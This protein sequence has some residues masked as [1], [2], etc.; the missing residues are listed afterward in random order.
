MDFQTLKIFQEV[1][2]TGSFLATAKNINYAQSNISTR[3]Q[4]LESELGTSLFYRNNR[5]VTLTPKGQLFLEYAESM[6][7]MMDDSITAMRETDAAHGSLHVGSLE[8][9]AQIYLPDILN[10]YHRENDQVALSVTCENSTLLISNILDRT[11]DLA[12]IAGDFA[13][14]DLISVPFTQE[15]MVFLT[16]DINNKPASWEDLDF[17]SLLVFKEGCYYR[18]TLE[19]MLRENQIPQQHIF[20]FNSAGALLSNI[21]AGLGVGYLPSALLDIL[22]QAKNIT[23]IEPPEKYQ[24]VSTNLIYRKDHYKDKA[25]TNFINLLLEERCY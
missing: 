15:H 23:C 16:A 3:M 20:D 2:N 18:A 12:I 8:T 24:T 6:L 7:K 5:G 10:Q 17:S 14:P 25:F 11:L 19:Q 21:C 1:A 9:I 22:P 4:Q 13:H